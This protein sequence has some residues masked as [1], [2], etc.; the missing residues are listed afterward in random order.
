[1]IDWKRAVVSPDATIFEA[2]T[3]IENGE[4]QVA[5]VT[6]DDDRLLGVV[7]DGDLRRSIIRGARLDDRITPIVN[8]SPVVAHPS[9]S[10]A[11]IRDRM[12]AREVQQIPLVSDEGRVVGIEVMSTMLKPELRPNPV[13]LM[14]GGLGTRLH[15]LT[16]DCPKPLIEV[17]GRPILQTVLDGFRRQGFHKFYLSV[18]Y[19]AE[20]I[21]EYFGDGS[22]WGVSIEYL[23]EDKRLGTAG[24]LSLLPEPPTTPVL[25][26]NGDL[27]TNLN[28]TRLLDYHTEQ[29]AKATMGV[30]QYDMQV[31]YGVIQINGLTISNIKE[32]PT[33]RYFVNAGL[34][35]LEPDVLDY[36]PHNEF[37]DMP[38]LFDEVLA[39][40]QDVAAFPIREYWQDIGQ[41]DDLHRAMSDYDSVFRQPHAEE[42]ASGDSLPVE[43]IRV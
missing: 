31:P 9:E 4:L 6:D 7:T 3:S 27:L 37:Y 20:M 34:Y 43:E 42:Y 25:I 24:P 2:M 13:V 15:P 29:K 32:K 36:I 40:G 12:V 26:A 5:L 28:F 33:E 11:T 21:E 39:A 18:N 14:A 19:M 17:G 1:M 23:R 38:T 30:R 10:P 35:V 8:T 22:K 41:P 16:E